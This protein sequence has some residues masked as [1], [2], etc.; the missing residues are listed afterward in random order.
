MKNNNIGPITEI[1]G[2]LVGAVTNT[3]RLL[4]SLTL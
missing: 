4:P 2:T 3:E 1:L